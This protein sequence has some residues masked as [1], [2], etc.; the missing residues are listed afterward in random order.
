MENEYKQAIADG[1]GLYS[2]QKDKSILVNSIARD[3]R[4]AYNVDSNKVHGRDIDKIEPVLR[5][6]NID[7][8]LLK[9]VEVTSRR[10]GEDATCRTRVHVKSGALIIADIFKRFD[11]NL[12]INKIR[13]SELIWQTFV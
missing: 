3:M 1:L 12:E 9:W 2:R 11:N 7:T 6:E 5:R 8:N 10:R 13:P 4:A